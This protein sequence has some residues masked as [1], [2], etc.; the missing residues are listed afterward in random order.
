[1]SKRKHTSTPVV[2]FLLLFHCDQ[3]PEKDILDITIAVLPELGSRFFALYKAFEV[4]TREDRDVCGRTV[5]CR[6]LKAI[7][8]EN[9]EPTMQ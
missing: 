5:G 4:E 6:R 3:M 8:P 9:C 2:T 7:A 1:M